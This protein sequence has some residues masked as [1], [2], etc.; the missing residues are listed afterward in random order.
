MSEDWFRPPKL[1][2]MARRGDRERWL[3]IAEPEAHKG[4]FG[5][6]YEVTESVVEEMGEK[7]RTWASDVAR[8]E[9]DRRI[10]AGKPYC[11]EGALWDEFEWQLPPLTREEL[12]ALS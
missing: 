5:V 10:A 2:E 12:E 8:K 4:C 11:G 9:L 7:I 1:R 6:G 3:W